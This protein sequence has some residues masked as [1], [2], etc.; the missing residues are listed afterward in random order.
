LAQVGSR[1]VTVAEVEEYLRRETGREPSTLSPELAGSL[2]E[3]YLREEVLLAA[4]KNGAPASLSPEQRSALARQRLE[5]LCPVPPPDLSQAA[6]GPAEAQEEGTTSAERILLRQLVLPDAAAARSARERL[7]RNEDFAEVSRA[8]SRAPNAATGG[9]LGWVERGQLP[10]EFEAAV[11]ALPRGGISAPVASDAGWHIFQV[12]DRRTGLGEE[13]QRQRSRRAAAAR[14]AE[15]AQRACL[16][17]LASALKIQVDCRA[18]TFPCRNPF[19]EK[20]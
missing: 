3:L 4:G 18:A 9:M 7:L 20:S 12:M 16:D 6:A 1:V 19:E 11:A 8:V 13:E 17:H 10:P 15:A 5:E 14:E 2:M